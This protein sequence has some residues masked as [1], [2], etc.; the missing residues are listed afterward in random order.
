MLATVHDCFRISHLASVH[1]PAWPN[2]LS[3]WRD[4]PF[5]MQQGR[6]TPQPGMHEMAI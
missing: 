5:R 3:L 2:N 1:F 4:W 6:A